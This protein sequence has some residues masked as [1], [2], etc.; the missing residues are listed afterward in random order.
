MALMYTP[1]PA[2]SRL[3]GFVPSSLVRAAQNDVPVKFSELLEMRRVI[4]QMVGD[5][6]AA[7]PDLIPFFATGNTPDFTDP[8][9]PEYGARGEKS[10]SPVL[11]FGM[12]PL[13]DV[14]GRSS[15]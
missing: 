11:F 2:E 4:E 6:H 12:I 5:L 7:Q 1:H 14:P 13:W 8:N 15:E 10:R 9:N 3:Q